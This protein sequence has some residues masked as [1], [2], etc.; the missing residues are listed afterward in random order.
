[1]ANSNQNNKKLPIN[2]QDNFLNKV[3]TERIQITVFF[4]NGYQLKGIVKS[5]D[6]FTILLVKDGKEMLLY[7]HAITTIAPAKPVNLEFM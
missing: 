6:N 2:L 7:K 4:V 5:F 3:R 1:M